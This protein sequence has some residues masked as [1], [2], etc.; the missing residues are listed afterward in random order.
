M[1]LLKIVETQKNKRLKGKFAVFPILGIFNISF[2]CKY[3][4]NYLH[5]IT[6]RMRGHVFILG[7]NVQF[8]GKGMERVKFYLISFSP[9]N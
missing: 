6:S 1:I 4:K 9:R 8:W 2:Y 3:H 7:N 5:V